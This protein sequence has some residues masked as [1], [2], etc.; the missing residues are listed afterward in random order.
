MESLYGTLQERA[1]R[2]CRDNGMPNEIVKVKARTLSTEEAIGNPEADDFPLQKGKERLIQARFGNGSGQAFTDQFGDYEGLLMDILAM[3]LRNN[4]RRAVFVATINALL[5]HMGRITG[6]IHCKDREPMDCARKLA[7]HLIERYG[8]VRVG[9]VGFQPRMVEAIGEAFPVRLLDLDQENI[10][11]RRFGV[12]VEGP[13]AKEDV[14]DWADLLL[15][16]GSTVANGT[17]D[18]FLGRKPVIFYGTTV[19]GAA[20]LM[21]WERFC[22]CSH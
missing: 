15:V 18:Q 17:I 12:L 11:T 13:V 21:G 2:L 1:L 10:G 5:H 3:P 16:T 6:T 22:V 20:H 4:Y 19:A 7:T 9:Q 8:E 14:I